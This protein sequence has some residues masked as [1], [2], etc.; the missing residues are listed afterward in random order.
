MEKPKRN[1][2]GWGEGWGESPT[3]AEEDQS[4]AAPWVEAE[5]ISDTTQ[6]L[7]HNS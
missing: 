7:K 5:R 1:G 3:E 2:E 4:G 6:D